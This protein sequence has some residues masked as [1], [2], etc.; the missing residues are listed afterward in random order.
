HASGSPRT[1]A[2][3]RT[4]SKPS[5]IVRFVSMGS[6]VTPFCRKW[7]L[8]A[9]PARLALLDEGL[10]S[11]LGVPAPEDGLEFLWC[12]PA[13]LG[14]VQHRSPHELFCRPDGDRPVGGDGGG[15]GKAGV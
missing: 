3:R 6:I 8:T 9:L 13:T 11:L 10:R 12:R 14:I 1:S 4:P 5:K 15:Q 7:R 2:T